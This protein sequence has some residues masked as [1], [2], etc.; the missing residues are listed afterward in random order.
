[1]SRPPAD[2]RGRVALVTGARQ[3]LGLAFA[4]ALA[5]EGAIVVA[6]DNVDAPGLADKLQRD[7]GEPALFLQ[8]D[9]SSPEQVE[10]AT[11]RIIDEFGRCDIVVNNAGVNDHR[12][13]DEIGIEDW[14]R[15]MRINVDSVFMVCRGLVGSMT[16]HGYGRIVNI[17]SDTLGHSIPGFAH[18]MASKGAVVGLTR[19]MANDLGASGITVNCI[20]PGLTRTP[21]TERAPVEVFDAMMKGQAIKRHALPQDLVGAMSFLTSDAA[22][23]VTGQT[24]IVNGGQLKSI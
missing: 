3:G 18:Y 23:F 19:G 24:L 7:S 11:G 2:K 8:C 1:M 22:G 12:P 17:A 13:F 4:E 20:A 21:R 16:K 14:R 9:V 5:L 6:L 15:V 10:E